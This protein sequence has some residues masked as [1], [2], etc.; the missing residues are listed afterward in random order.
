MAASWGD[1]VKVARE[2]ASEALE[3]FGIA[4]LQRRFVHELSSGQTQMFA[5]ALTLIRP[6][7]VLLLDEPEQRLDAERRA[8]LADILA[9]RVEAGTTLIMATHSPDL[10]A[11]TRARELHLIEDVA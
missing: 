3:Q 9:A 7:E 2:A 5:L 11:G 8:L 4:R 10:V 6:S 1:E